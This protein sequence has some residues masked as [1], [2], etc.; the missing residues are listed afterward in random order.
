MGFRDWLSKTM[1]DGTGGNWGY[2]SDADLDYGRFTRSK[3][4]DASGQ[5]E[6]DPEKMYLGFLKKQPSKTVNT[7]NTNLGDENGIFN[8]RSS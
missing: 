3:R 7:D 8:P 5:V 4:H 2:R 6:L 1:P